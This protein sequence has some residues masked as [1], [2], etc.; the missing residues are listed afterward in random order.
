MT[1]FVTSSILSKIGKRRKKK[2]DLVFEKSSTR[3]AAQVIAN[4][5]LAG[6]II[7]SAFYF[8]HPNWYPIFLG[9]LAAVTSD[10]WAT[11]IGVY[12]KSTPRSVLTFKKVEPGTSGGISL[13]GTLGGALG[14]FCIALSGYLVNPEL[15]LKSS[16]EMNFFWIILSGVLGSLVDSLL[17][18]TLQSQ[19]LCNLCGKVTERRVHC[20]KVTQLIRGWE[21]FHNDRVNM[22]CGL[23]GG[24]VV[25]FVIF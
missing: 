7:V 20:E 8:P 3:D 16:L 22:I 14:A 2:F 10:T 12:F 23:A 9:I 1:F 4:G 19:Y 6:L 24:I 18:A 15:F 17:G 21:F 5:G 13:I 25:Y 11:E